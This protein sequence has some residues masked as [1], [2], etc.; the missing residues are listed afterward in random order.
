SIG[1]EMMARPL[2]IPT[3]FVDILEGLMLIFFAVGVFLERLYLPAAR[4]QEDTEAGSASLEDP[5]LPQAGGEPAA[6][7]TLAATGDRP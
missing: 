1:G 5:E 4:L 6:G 7:P 2:N 3:Y